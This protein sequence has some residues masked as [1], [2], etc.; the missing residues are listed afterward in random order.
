MKKILYAVLIIGYAYVSFA[1]VK[2]EVENFVKK[3]VNSKEFQEANK[4]INSLQEQ[5]NKLSRQGKYEEAMQCY[6]KALAQ[7]DKLYGKES[8][9]AAMLYTSMGTLFLKQGEKIKGAD[10]F[11]IAAKI[12]K[13]SMGAIVR[14]QTDIFLLIR[15]GFIYFESQCYRMACLTLE[16]AQSDVKSFSTEEKEKYLPKLN[17]Y[18]GI[19]YLKEKQYKKA[20]PYLQKSIEYENKQLF[21][22]KVKLS[23]YHLFLGEAMLET[24][25]I[26]NVLNNL[27]E[28]KKLAPWN[29]EA[30]FDYYLS[31]IF[32]R[33][34]KYLN[35]D[36]DYLSYA[37]QA[38]KIAEKFQDTDSRKTI[39]KL[40]LAD[41]NYKNGF[42]DDANKILQNAISFAK[43]NSINVKIIDRMNNLQKLW[44][45]KSKNSEKAEV[46][47]WQGR[48]CFDGN[49]IDDAR[50]FFQEA[51]KF[52]KAKKYP[53]YR[54]LSKVY[55]WE[56][57]I[58]YQF[59]Q[60]EKSAV[61]F[62]KSWETT[63][64]TKN[65]VNFTI[66]LANKLSVCYHQ[67][68]KIKKAL[69]FSL[70]AYEKQKEKHG[71]NFQTAVYAFTV[72]SAYDKL[73]DKTNALKYLKLAHE[74]FLKYK[75]ENPR[76]SF[77]TAKYIEKIYKAR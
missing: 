40:V 16:Q 28:S 15:A 33:A 30:G 65:N 35:S 70:L 50:K 51:L 43:K 52:E 12:Y 69:K 45:V 8:T 49:R 48:V 41:A 21:P 36:E 44:N 42:I 5:G 6:Q 73:K 63:E 66:Q 56:G 3:D 53:N 1:D 75:R 27:K 26:R 72:G 76:A 38:E 59:S 23:Q 24:G 61:I 67:T 18:L 47:Y 34:Y 60:W 10:N 11:V 14:P 25:N 55:F 13:K 39:A 57:E 2:K 32:A 46:A 62:E 17:E 19:A 31:R 4:L 68:G 29:S 22:S 37:K 74:I 71:N 64:Q 7:A 58:Y 9:A 54:L 20:I 77:K